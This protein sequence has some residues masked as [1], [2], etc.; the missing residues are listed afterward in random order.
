VARVS[1][2]DAAMPASERG[3]RAGVV[4]GVFFAMVFFQK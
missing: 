1:A 3:R 2:T 4:V